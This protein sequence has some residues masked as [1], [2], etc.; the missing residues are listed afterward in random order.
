MSEKDLYL[1]YMPQI[2]EVVIV[3]DEE[4]YINWKREILE[5]TPRKGMYFMERLLLK[6][7]EIRQ[8]EQ[9]KLL[10]LLKLRT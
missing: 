6:C 2:V 9:I 10:L 7:D 4:E 3:M 5:A 1:T 8:H